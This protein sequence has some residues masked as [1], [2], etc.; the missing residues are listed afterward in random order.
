MS[1]GSS[2]AVL[3]L[4]CF[5][6]LTAVAV[7]PPSPQVTAKC[8]APTYASDFLVCADADLLRLDDL[9][10]RLIAQRREGSGD[11]GVGESDEDWFRRSRACAFE[12]DHHGCLLAA[13]CAR[14]ALLQGGSPHAP[15]GCDVPAAHYLAASSISRSGFAR[16]GDEMRALHGQTIRIWG[17]VDHR[18]VYGDGSAKEILGDWWSG[19]GPD[20]A[21]WRF[22]LKAKD[23]DAVGRSFPVHVPA[24]QGRDELL[25]AFLADARADRPTK[26]YLEGRI[27]TFDAPTSGRR[28]TGLRMEL[29][30]SRNIRLQPPARR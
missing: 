14:I 17:F 12:A 9:L 18:N 1:A 19:P 13:Y 8:D 25:K 30:S 16:H 28:L 27:F 11:L 4:S 22:N 10:A 21:T 5:A 3:L 7:P 29:E 26:I 24:D 15:A 6:P 20:A 2:T 23:D